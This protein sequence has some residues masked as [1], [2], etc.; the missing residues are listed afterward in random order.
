MTIQITQLHTK[1]RVS[2]HFFSKEI[3]LLLFVAALGNNILYSL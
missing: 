2:F 1:F 3:E